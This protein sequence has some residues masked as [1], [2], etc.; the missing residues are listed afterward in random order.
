[1]TE[2]DGLTTTQNYIFS[3]FNS[4]N[5]I[6]NLAALPKFAKCCFIAI[7][8]NMQFLEI[9]RK[10]AERRLI[11]VGRINKKANRQHNI[12]LGLG[13]PKFWKIAIVMPENLIKIGWKFKSQ[14]N[15][16][17]CLILTLPR[18]D[19]I[20]GQWPWIKGLSKN[21]NWQYISGL[22]SSRQSLVIFHF[23]FTP[24]SGSKFASLLASSPLSHTLSLSSSLA[25][26]PSLLIFFCT[27]SHL[28]PHNNHNFTG[29]LISF[30]LCYCVTN[31]GFVALKV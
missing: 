8:V 7:F 4:F 16:K 31:T 30:K 2:I 10:S 19:L 18:A 21:G 27:L 22:R 13:L 20:C 9:W 12:I 6:V 3:L 26:A 17:K 24:S 15:L 28:T 14:F 11:E 23:H 5:A 29:N 25:H 1:M